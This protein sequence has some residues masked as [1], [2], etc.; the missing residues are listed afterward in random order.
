MQTEIEV[1]E[2]VAFSPILRAMRE[3]GRMKDFDE[4]EIWEMT[5]NRAAE[6]IVAV[7]GIATAVLAVGL[8]LAVWLTW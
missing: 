1:A 6:R 4:R 7:L 2:A 8:V 3:Q 5:D